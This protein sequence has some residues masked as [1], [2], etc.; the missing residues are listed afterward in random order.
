MKVSII[1]VCKNAAKTIEKAIQSVLEQTYR[2]IEYVVIDGASEDGT[3]EILQAYSDRISTLISEPDA[4]I[5]AAMNKGIRL[6]TGTFL[7]FLNADDYLFDSTVIQD[8]VQFVTEHPKC[9][10]VYGDHEARFFSGHASI[11]QPAL[12]EMMLEEMVCLGECLIQPASFF[13]ADLFTRLGWFEERYRIASDYEWFS[14]LIQDQ[15]ITLHYYPRTLVSY[16]HGGASSNIRALF[17]EVFAIQNSIPL[18]QQDEWLKKRL[19]KLQQAFID[20]YDLLERTDKL[21]IAR[22]RDIMG[23]EAR[24]TQLRDEVA[25]LKAEVEP[26]RQAHAVLENKIEAMKTSKFWQLRSLWFRVKRKLGLPVDSED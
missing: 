16:S 8:L 21:A 2:T 5:Y 1:T 4:G 13:K 9:E 17:E 20:K 22:Y 19:V 3:K 10:F 7:Y 25:T 18:Y 24:I 14:R 12:P 15:T 6:A 26:L 23:L 11:H